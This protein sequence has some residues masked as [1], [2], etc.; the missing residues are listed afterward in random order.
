MKTAYL[1]L[2]RDVTMPGRSPKPFGAA[3]NEK[4]EAKKFCQTFK[5]RPRTSLPMYEPIVLGED[6]IWR[7]KRGWW[8]IPK[9]SLTVF[10]TMEDAL[11]GR[12]V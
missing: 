3:V 8:N 9:E 11:A 10:D 5:D 4:D 1:L 12:N 7:S 2:T 6:N